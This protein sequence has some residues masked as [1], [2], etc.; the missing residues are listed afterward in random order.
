MG[1]ITGSVGNE[2]Y[3]QKYI[4]GLETE[5]LLVGWEFVEEAVVGTYLYRVWKNP[6]SLNRESKDFYVILRRLAAPTGASTF[7]WICAGREYKTSSTPANITLRVGYGYQRSTSSGSVPLYLSEN[8]TGRDLVL[9]NLPWVASPITSTSVWWAAVTENYLS[10]FTTENGKVCYAGLYLVYDHYRE[11]VQALGLEDIFIPVCSVDL[12][13]GYPYYTTD[14]RIMNT[15]ALPGYSGEYV[16]YYN[17]SFFWVAILPSETQIINPSQPGALEAHYPFSYWEIHAGRQGSASNAWNITD[18][19]PITPVGRLEGVGS[20][21]FPSAVVRGDTVHV[22]DPDAG[23]TET[24]VVTQSRS[25]GTL[26]CISTG[27]L[28]TIQE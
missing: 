1:Y 4:L 3:P 11:Q 28:L 18:A 27:S 5:M 2:D 8:A 12:P 24:Y 6:A 23:T 14:N 16:D 26:A 25:S 22:E 10:T 13:D 17:N 19:V 20:C 7:V 15:G 9:Q 21:Y